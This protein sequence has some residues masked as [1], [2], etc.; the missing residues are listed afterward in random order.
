[1]RW[2]KLGLGLLL[3]CVAVARGEETPP[4]I[5]L[6]RVVKGLQMLTDLTDDG[7]GRLYVT[8]KEGRVRVIEGGK[9]RPEPLLDIADRVYCNN[10]CG[11]LGVRFHPDYKRNGRFF[12]D[13]TT[14]RPKQKG[15]DTP[16]TLKTIVAEFHADPATGIADPRSERVIL[17]VDQ[18][19]SNHNGGQLQFGPDGFLYLSLGDGG[20]HDDPHKGAQDLGKLYGK[21][22][23]IDVSRVGTYEIPSDNPF[24]ARAGARPE[25]WA[26]GLRNPWRFSFDRETGTCFAGDVGQN[27]WEEV[28][29]I[30]K[31]GNYGWRP[32][33]GFHANPNIPSEEP[34]GEVIDPIA[35]YPHKP[36]HAH[37]IYGKDVADLSVTGG[38]VYRG[39]KYPALRG[40]YLYADY[41]SGRIWGL[42]YDGGK[43]TGRGLMLESRYSI[44]SFGED[45]EGE[46]YVVDHNGAV[47]RVGL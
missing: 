31:G 24:A 41:A 27:M 6:E 23:R 39:K 47:Y 21:I 26:W 33:E 13:Y 10:E 18:P 22:L 4:A 32:R 43:V 40:W 1:M 3:G 35:E 14:G 36:P 11:L 15:K 45:H 19:F 34:A 38:Y 46:L 2:T 37:A 42:K 12:V 5:K 44:S 29:V 17:T 30:T 7:T 9:V 8:E 20:N 28:D 25:I 16:N